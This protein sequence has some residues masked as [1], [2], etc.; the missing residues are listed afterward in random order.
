MGYF[1][2][3]AGSGHHD[4]V[5]IPVEWH[6]AMGLDPGLRGFAGSGLHVG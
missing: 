1:Q 4:V 2:F 3:H 6:A 5:F